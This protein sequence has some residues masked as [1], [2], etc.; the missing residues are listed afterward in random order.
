MSFFELYRQN[1][2]IF[3]PCVALLVQW[4]QKHKIMSGRIYGNPA[5]SIDLIYNISEISGASVIP[6]P[7]DDMNIL[8][9]SY[10]FKFSDT[11]VFP[12]IITFSS[13]YQLYEL[14][15]SVNL[16]EVSEN[17]MNFNG[18]HRQKIMKQWD[19]VF[20]KIIPMKRDI[21][22]KSNRQAPI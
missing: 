18:R 15:A 16:T 17:M 14:L 12:H 21:R 19:N 6:N 8:S 7:N 3:T 11:Y 4:H 22:T 9:N 13:W 1:I 5:R 20:E 2:P 10:W